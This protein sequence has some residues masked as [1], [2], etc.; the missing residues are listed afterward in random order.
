M[1]MTHWPRNGHSRL[2]LGFQEGEKLNTPLWTPAHCDHPRPPQFHWF[3][4][5]WDI[6]LLETKK[7]SNMPYK[8][9]FIKVWDYP[10]PPTYIWING[11][12]FSGIFWGGFPYLSFEE[13]G[14]I[15]CE[16][17]YTEMCSHVTGSVRSH[18]YQ[19]CVDRVNLE[20]KICWILQWN[21][22]FKINQNRWK[23]C[24]L[25]PLSSSSKSLVLWRWKILLFSH[26]FQFPIKQQTIL[27]KRQKPDLEMT[28]ANL[29][30]WRCQ[31]SR[32]WEMSSQRLHQKTKLLVF[33][34]R[35]IRE[36]VKNGYLMVR[37]TIKGGGGGHP[38]QSDY[39]QMRKVWH[40]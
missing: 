12:K 2:V 32:N 13:M 38:S 22:K 24:T 4:Q 31:S 36:A 15:C 1:D 19:D 26:N 39:K 7:G 17:K 14:R 16:Y 30:I 9:W 33:F 11:S 34:P 21:S 28:G 35:V 40:F 27:R 23:S 37:M 8:H 20:K 18:L 6:N 25:Q 5:I 29:Q 10:T 3:L